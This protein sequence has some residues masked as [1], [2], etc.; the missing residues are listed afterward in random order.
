M[1]THLVPPDGEALTP[2]CGKTPFELPIGDQITSD[3]ETVT[4][5]ELVP[6]HVYG[7]REP[8]WIPREPMFILLKPPADPEHIT[9]AEMSEAIRVDRLVATQ[10]ASGRWEI[11]DET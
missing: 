1:T 10:I 9:V 5:C 11:E 3:G 7:E 2:C 4:C 6:E 8:R